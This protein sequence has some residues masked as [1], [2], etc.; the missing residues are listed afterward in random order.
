M[1][2]LPYTYGP[3]NTT[4]FEYLAAGALGAVEPGL[5]LKVDAGKLAKAEANDKPTYIGML[6]GDVAD[7]DVIPVIRVFEE[8]VFETANSVENASAEVGAKYT[9]DDTG[10]MITATTGGAAEL[11]RIGDTAK[12][13]TMYVRFVGPDAAE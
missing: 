11:V 13:G 1:A 2:F 9:I 3:G 4:P 5:A 7:G 8:T 6:R 12:G 10:S